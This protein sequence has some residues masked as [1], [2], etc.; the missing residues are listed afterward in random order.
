MSGELSPADQVEYDRRQ[1]AWLLD[2]R[3]E[4]EDVERYAQ[5]PVP[6][7][8]QARIAPENVVGRLGPELTAMARAAR[9]LQA[10]AVRLRSNPKIAAEDVSTWLGRSWGAHELLALGLGVH[11]G[12]S[13]T[14]AT[15]LADGLTGY[16]AAGTPTG[17]SHEQGPVG[18]R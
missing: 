6:M 17:H 5:T 7:F 14:E 1:A 2:W 9:R 4:I 16:D 10:E 8:D 18:D 11:L 12:L 15:W 13:H 3:D